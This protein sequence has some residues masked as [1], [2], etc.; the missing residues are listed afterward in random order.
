MNENIPLQEVIAYN[1][2]NKAQDLLESYGYNAAKD[3]KDL[4]YKLLEFSKDY[5][6]EAIEELA[7]IHPHKDLILN[8]QKA[9]IET[10]ED[11][12]ECSCNSDKNHKTT[13]VEN[14]Y[15]NAEG[16]NKGGLTQKDMKDKFMDYLP[17]MVVA[18]IFTLAI[19][20]ITKK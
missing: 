11:K 16:D 15:V 13:K 7:K 20:S 18:S 14:D 1:N 17:M 8:F 10:K 3:Y 19:V 6:E 12:K 2:T 4:V 5:K 9:K